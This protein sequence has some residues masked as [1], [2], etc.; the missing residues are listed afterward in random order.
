MRE[1]NKQQLLPGKEYPESNEEYWIDRSIRLFKKGLEKRYGKEKFMRTF[2]PKMHG[3][4]KA[5]FIIEPNLI[6]EYYQG[7]F[8]EGK[9]YFAWARFSNA[10]PKVTADNKK[11]GRGFTKY[12]HYQ[13]YDRPLDIIYNRS[14]L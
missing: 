14:R 3:C 8:K 1:L 5:A 2:H 9:V 12:P 4:V 13:I 11:T 10:K 6:P 7:I